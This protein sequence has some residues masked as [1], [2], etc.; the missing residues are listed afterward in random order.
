[1]Y[2]LRCTRK[3]LD[4]AAV[5]VQQTS[6]SPTTVLGDW[7][8]NILFCRPHHLV[9]CLSERTL[10]PVVAL[11]KDLPALPRRL[12]S[13]LHEVLA[14]LGIPEIAITAE[15]DQM[16]SMCFAPTASRRI[17]GA[18]NDFMYHFEA[19]YDMN[20]NHS[21]LERA[22][23][24]AEMPTKILEYNSAES[25]TRELFAAARQSDRGLR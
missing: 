13:G 18:M 20:P 2:A 11:A 24:L 23:S 4:R 5:Q 21:M 8:A 15:L 10:L 22:R 7:Y 25:A 6:D 3:L 16:E 12:Q 19:E 1:M 14:S 17:I 9:L